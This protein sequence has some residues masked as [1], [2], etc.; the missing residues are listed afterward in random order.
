MLPAG[1]HGSVDI[2]VGRNVLP[3]DYAG[4]NSASYFA[5]LMYPPLVQTR[6]VRL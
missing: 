5:G 1:E 6:G 2:Y 3:T 4:A